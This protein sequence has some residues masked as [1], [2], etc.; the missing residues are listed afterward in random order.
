MPHR[1]SVGKRNVYMSSQNKLLALIA[2]ALCLSI[3]V[4]AQKMNK[5]T[6]LLYEKIIKTYNWKK[7]NV[8]FGDNYMKKLGTLITELGIERHIGGDTY[9]YDKACKEARQRFLE[10]SELYFMG[11]PCRFFCKWVSPWGTPYLELEVDSLYTTYPKLQKL[12]SKQH[13]A[14]FKSLKEWYVYR[15]IE[16]Y[17]ETMTQKVDSAIALF[18]KYKTKSY[19]AVVDGQRKDRLEEYDRKVKETLDAKRRA[20]DEKINPTIQT[21]QC[22]DLGLSVYWCGYNFGADSPEQVGDF[23]LWGETKPLK[24]HAPTASHNYPRDYNRIRNPFSEDIELTFYDVVS[25]K[26]GNGWHIPRKSEVIELMSR[27]KFHKGVYRGVLGLQITGPN[28]NS[29]FLPIKYAYILAAYKYYSSE[30]T[31]GKMVPD[32]ASGA[33]MKE[34]GGGIIFDGIYREIP[35]MIRPVK[36]K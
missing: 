18:R 15:F 35:G 23:Y 10:Y 32:I 3:S 16:A 21:Q 31:H 33:C 19:D 13:T 7:P 24:I 12:R 30:R 5:K 17:N 20:E 14:L 29:I 1:A 9:S 22:V 8:T 2:I 28:G 4:N 34:Y 27:C 6:Q 25:E 26:W 36:S 11:K